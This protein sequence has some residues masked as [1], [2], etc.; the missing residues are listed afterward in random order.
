MPALVCGPCFGGSV[1]STAFTNCRPVFARRRGRP[2]SET[3]PSDP[4]AQPRTGRTHGAAASLDDW[5][6]APLGDRERRDLLELIE[7]S[8]GRRATLITSQLPIEHWHNMIGDATFGD[9]ILDRLVHH[10]HHV[11]HQRRLLP[12]PREAESRAHEIHPHPSL[13]GVR[14]TG[15]GI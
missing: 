15:W 10:A 11:Q 6:L 8:A 1:S 4:T 5:G 14:S 2:S 9:A 12:R 3:V 7:H 13:R